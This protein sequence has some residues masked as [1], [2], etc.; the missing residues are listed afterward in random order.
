MQYFLSEIRVNFVGMNLTTIIKLLEDLMIEGSAFPNFFYSPWFYNNPTDEN[1]ELLLDVMYIG[2]G[3]EQVAI[4]F[5]L[6]MPRADSGLPRE[7]FFFG[8]DDPE[9]HVLSY[10]AFGPRIPGTG[11]G[12]GLFPRVVTTDVLQSYRPEAAGGIFLFRDIGGVPGKYDPAVDHVIKLD[13]ANFRFEPFF[14]DPE[15][16]QD[17]SHPMRNVLRQLLPGQV[18]N[19]AMKDVIPWLYQDVNLGA[20]MLGLA[21]LPAPVEEGMSRPPLGS[22]ACFLDPDCTMFDMFINVQ[23]P[24]LGLTEGQMRYLVE[25]TEENGRTNAEDLYGVPLVNGF[26]FVMPIAPGNPIGDLTVPSS[27]TGDNA[28]PDFYLA[29]RTSN[30]IQNLDSFVPFIRPQDITVGTNLRQFTQGDNTNVERIPSVSSIGWGRPGTSSTS[31]MIGRPEPLFQFND[32]TQPGLQGENLNNNNFIFDRAMGSPPKAV[33]GIDVQD[34]GANPTG[35]INDAG[36]DQIMYQEF[37]TESP[38]G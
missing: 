22:L 13:T 36:S 19:T 18:A 26:T 20:Q 3:E 1:G 28:G 8:N 9:A 16:I 23:R 29:I 31:A 30:A 33:I 14:V 37:F 24:F 25:Y 5:P 2:E 11:G 17:P 27:R 6:T 38:A 10:T 34:F 21:E 12:Q 4:K 7:A 32:L 35:T 15:Q